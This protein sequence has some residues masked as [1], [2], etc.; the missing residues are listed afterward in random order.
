MDKIETR[1]FDMANDLKTPEDVA[2][3]LETV[4]EQGD[5]EDLKAALGDIVR[6]WGMMEIA[7]RTGLTRSHLCKALSPEGNPEFA[8]IASVL[9]ALGLR[10]AVAADTADR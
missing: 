9:K 4:L 8:T 5:A 1:P 10:V 7:A 2:I 3:Y 6:S